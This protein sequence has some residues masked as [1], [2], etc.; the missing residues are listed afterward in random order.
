[1]N[2]RAVSDR[3]LAGRFA[4]IDLHL[5]LDGSLSLR[6]VRELASMQCISVPESDHELLGM[7]QVGPDCRD[8]NEYLEKFDFPCA[9]LQTEAAITVAVRNLCRELEDQGLLY[10]EIRFAPQLHTMQGL[11]QAEVVRAAVAGLRQCGLRAN[12]ILC[13]M[14]GKQNHAENLE[15]VSVAAEYLGRGVCAVDLAGAEALF[16]TEDFGELFSFAAER[17]V[18]FTIHA[19]EADGPESVRT[20]LGFGARRIGHGVRSVEDETLLRRL[21]DEG[22]T[23]ELCPTSNLNT[24]IFERIQDYP[25][26]RLLDSGVRVT[27]N[28]DNLTVSNVS[29]RSELELICRTFSLSAWQAWQLA[30]NAAEASFADPETKAWLL[31]E[32][33]GRFYG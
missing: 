27:I 19:G 8:L 22:I 23:L 1:M 18:P 26:P 16:P 30:R 5:H 32:I 9:L 10:A 12:L 21:A 2:E 25:L 31:E 11:T 3:E 20:A 6:T 28:S 7:L 15:T 33:D 4:L 17:C 29:L 14:R 13:C 24:N